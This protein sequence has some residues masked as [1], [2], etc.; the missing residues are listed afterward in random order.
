MGYDDQELARYTHPPLTTTLLPNTR[1]VRRLRTLIDM[2]VH[3]KPVRPMVL[4]VDGPVVT[5]AT[6]AAWRR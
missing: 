6:T 1:W 5:R 2:A 3:G 4:K